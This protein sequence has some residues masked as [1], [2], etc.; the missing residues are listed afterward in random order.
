MPLK[1]E[2]VAP[3]ASSAWR[4]V[5]GTQSRKATAEGR[6]RPLKGAKGDAQSFGSRPRRAPHRHQMRSSC[7]LR[8]VGV[9]QMTL[10]SREQQS[11]H[12]SSLRDPIAVQRRARRRAACQPLRARPSDCRRA[13]LWGRLQRIRTPKDGSTSTPRRLSTARALHLAHSARHA[14]PIP[15]QR[16]SRWRLAYRSS[17]KDARR[18]RTLCAAGYRVLRVTAQPVLHSLTTVIACIRQALSQP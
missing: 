12:D 3:L 8:L 10:R 9:V 7:F 13:E 4:R 2:A 16:R 5:C 6:F 18:D 15:A 1:I 17:H 14:E 11:Q